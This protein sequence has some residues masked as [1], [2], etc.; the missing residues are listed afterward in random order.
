M[1]VCL[2][3]GKLASKLFLRDGH[4]GASGEQVMASLRTARPYTRGSP[5]VTTETGYRAKST[6]GFCLITWLCGTLNQAV[7]AGAL[8]LGAV[9]RAHRTVCAQLL[10]ETLCTCREVTN[11]LR[12]PGCYR[13]WASSFP[14]PLP[15]E[16]SPSYINLLWGC[17][18]VS[19]SYFRCIK[20]IKPVPPPIPSRK[21]S[22]P[23]PER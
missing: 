2:R 5:L 17:S 18:R 15:C 6:V 3:S 23:S 20:N 11:A 7:K 19:S 4:D 13:A 14:H 1:D 21:S 10:C 9:L 16:I 8:W 12:F 22:A